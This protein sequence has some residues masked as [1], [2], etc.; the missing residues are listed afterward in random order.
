MPEVEELQF[1]NRLKVQTS[2]PDYSPALASLFWPWQPW[3]QRRGA[4]MENVPAR[5]FA[6]PRV[7]LRN[8][9]DCIYRSSNYY[10]PEY[11]VCA[12]SMIFPFLLVLNTTRQ[13][14][15]GIY[16]KRCYPVC[17]VLAG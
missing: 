3:L 15:Y 14:G 13:N 17:G 10:L 9:R 4:L 2:I 8:Y 16:V 11:A 6:M 1:F 7:G 12:Y 5:V